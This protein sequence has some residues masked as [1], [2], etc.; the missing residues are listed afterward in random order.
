MIPLHLLHKLKNIGITDNIEINR[1]TVLVTGILGVANSAGIIYSFT[2]NNAFA[3]NHNRR[4]YLRENCELHRTKERLTNGTCNR[5]IR[6]YL[7]ILCYL[8]RNVTE[9]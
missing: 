3:E 7:H 2:A 8:L 6:F 9:K 4:I 1:T 5:T